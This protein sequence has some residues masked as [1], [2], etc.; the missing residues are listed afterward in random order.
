M[1]AQRW[2]WPRPRR[3]SRKAKVGRLSPDKTICCYCHCLALAGNTAQWQAARTHHGVQEEL[4]SSGASDP[5]KNCEAKCAMQIVKA[6]W[7]PV[8]SSI[9]LMP[10]ARNLAYTSRSCSEQSAATER[11]PAGQGEQEA[12][13]TLF[14]YVFR[15]L[16]GQTSNINMTAVNALAG[17][18]EAV[19][20]SRHK[21]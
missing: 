7:Q 19:A 4:A 8:C 1:T 2:G 20:S 9:A 21:W 13:P 17:A 18:P 14:A 3:C 15:G 5:G 12:W 11:L 6:R 16:H 10:T